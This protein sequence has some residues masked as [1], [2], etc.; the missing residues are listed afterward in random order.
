MTIGNA[1]TFIERGLKD[2]ALRNRLNSATNPSELQ[3]ALGDEKLEFSAHDF[4]EAFHH[5]L[6]QCQEEEDADQIK[7][8]KLWWYLLSR[9]LEMTACGNQCSG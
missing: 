2:S 5:R 9:S 4:D 3:N 1:L 8:F 7:E 6:T